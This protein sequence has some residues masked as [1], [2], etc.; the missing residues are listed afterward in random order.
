MSDPKYQQPRATL[1]GMPHR[2][3]PADMTIKNLK[4]K[5]KRSRAELEQLLKRLDKDISEYR[6]KI[7]PPKRMNPPKRMKKPYA[8]E[9]DI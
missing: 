8:E 5:N 7:T 6:P 2:N 3:R 1:V 4:E 9:Q